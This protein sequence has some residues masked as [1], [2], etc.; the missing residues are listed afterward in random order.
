M[1][2]ITR[3]KTARA[4]AGKR[5]EFQLRGRPVHLNEVERY[6]KRKSLKVKKIVLKTSASASPPPALERIKP[7]QI[8]SSPNTP[9]AL[10]IPEYIFS[11]IRDYFLGSFG[12]GTWVADGDVWDRFSTKSTGQRHEGLERPL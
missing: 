12:A 11:S 3:I 4:A 8:P 1:K 10:E 9:R 6:L 5:S 7:N 2:A